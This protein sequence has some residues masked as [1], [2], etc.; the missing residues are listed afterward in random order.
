[1]IRIEYTPKTEQ[2][3][4]IYKCNKDTE[5]YFMSDKDNKEE[6]EIDITEYTKGTRMDDSY[7]YFKIPSKKKPPPDTEDTSE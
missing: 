3:N 6:E 2:Q 5:I 7:Y 1:M 4:L